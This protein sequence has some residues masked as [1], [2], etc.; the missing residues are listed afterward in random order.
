MKRNQVLER[1]RGWCLLV[2][3]ACGADPAK[4]GVGASA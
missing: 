1:G 3:V 2:V 4:N